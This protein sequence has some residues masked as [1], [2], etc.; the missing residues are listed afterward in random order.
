MKSHS[1]SEF[2]ILR[3][4]YPDS[5]VLEFEKEIMELTNKFLES[6]QSGGSAPYYANAI[7]SCISKLLLFQP[8]SP[9]SGI[10]SEW[11]DISEICGGETTFINTRDSSVFKDG[12]NQVSKVS[13]ISF[14]DENGSCWSGSCWKSKSD[15]LTN[16]KSLKVT[17]KQLIS[18]FPFTPK[19][20]YIDVIMEEVNPDDWE[21]FCKN[22]EQLE[23]VLNYYN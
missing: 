21:M 11:S 5:I 18:K 16:D 19:T 10:D 9:L 8:I 3:N 2:E 6:G 20:F 13:A 22:P 14:K 23:E 1:L 15:Y 7:T 12:L 17:S 4:S